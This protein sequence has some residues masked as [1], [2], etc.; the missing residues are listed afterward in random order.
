[1]IAFYWIVQQIPYGHPE[2]SACSGSLKN[3]DFWGS[4]GFPQS[5]TV[6]I[7]LGET[8]TVAISATP[9]PPTYFNQIHGCQFQS[10]LPDITVHINAVNFATCTVIGSRCRLAS[11]LSNQQI[12]ANII[13]Q[14]DLNMF[15]TTNNHGCCLNIYFYQ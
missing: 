8:P 6:S 15:F 3:C 11:G 7:H 5:S 4:H 12:C 13:Y 9:G 1:M 2:T 10:V 14:S